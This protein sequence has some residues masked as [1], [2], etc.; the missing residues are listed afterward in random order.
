MLNMKIL[1]ITEETKPTKNGS[2]YTVL[3]IAYKN[4]DKNSTEGKKVFSFGDSEEAFKTLK[5]AQPGEVFAIEMKKGEKYW[6]WVKATKG[7]EAMAQQN[8]P[9]GGGGYTAQKRDYE[10][11]EERAARQVLICRQ[12]ALTNAVTFITATKKGAD[13]AEVLNVAQTMVNWTMQKS[14][15]PVADMSDDIPF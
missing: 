2:S 10:T 6:N 15:N 12:N 4:L 14:E 9:A 13:L 11:A 3:D 8:K 1:S 5:G 7:D